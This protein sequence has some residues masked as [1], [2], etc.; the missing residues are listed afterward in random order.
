MFPLLIAR[1]RAV[2]T[3]RKSV[4]NSLAEFSDKSRTVF[5]AVGC[6]SQPRIGA[7]DR[8]SRFLTAV[9]VLEQYASLI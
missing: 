9:I 3:A 5:Q 4:C 2:S 8:V 6:E 7:R 1:D